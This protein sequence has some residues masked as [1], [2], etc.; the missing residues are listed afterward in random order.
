MSIT[1]KIIFIH[2][3]DFGKKVLISVNIQRILKGNVL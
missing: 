1:I 3:K 2:G